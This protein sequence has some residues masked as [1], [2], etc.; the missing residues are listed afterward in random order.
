MPKNSAR[1]AS[2]IPISGASK[3]LCAKADTIRSASPGASAGEA[4]SAPALVQDRLSQPGLVVETE[5]GHDRS[6]RVHRADQSLALERYPDRGIA[7]PAGVAGCDY[8]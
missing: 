7:Q 2:G 6:I 8:G 4:P 5:R 1:S 3:P